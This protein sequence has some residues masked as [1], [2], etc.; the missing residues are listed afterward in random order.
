MLALD[1]KQKVLTLRLVSFRAERY[2]FVKFESSFNNKLKKFSAVQGK[3]SW[4]KEIISDCSEYS[5][6]CLGAKKNDMH[7]LNILFRASSLIKA[8]S[9]PV[10]GMIS[11]GIVA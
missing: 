3:V 11:S 8:W 2:S 6:L 7:T 10:L 1:G 5:Y 4:K 9:F